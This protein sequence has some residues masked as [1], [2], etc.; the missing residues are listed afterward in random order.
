MHLFVRVVDSGSFTVAAEQAGIS[1]AMAS[2]LIRN[3]EDV[4]GVRLL[5]R[6]TRRL[7]LTEPG[8]RYY[9]RIGDVLTR[10]GEADAEAAQLQVEPRGRLRVSAPISFSVF[11]LAPAV[12]EFQ[13]RHPHLELELSLSDYRV[14]LIDDRYDMAI[15]VSRLAD[16]SLV[17]RKIAP[18]RMCLVASPEYLEQHGEPAEPTHLPDH[19]CLR[20]TLTPRTDDWTLLRAGNEVS[21]HVTSRLSVNS[22]DFIAAAAVAGFGI[23]RL[24]TFIVA[25]H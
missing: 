23:A 2:K 3:L 8:Q 15:R 4:L 9:Q 6:S 7:S 22:G 18:C 10:L 11:H 25:E 24:P 20:Y 19:H 1:R 12:A 13:R 21:V 5:N 14:D 16:S 17:A